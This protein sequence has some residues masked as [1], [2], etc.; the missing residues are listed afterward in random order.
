L[1]NGLTES[2]AKQKEIE[3]I[4]KYKSN[5]KEFGYNLTKGG[6]GVKG[7]VHTEETKKKIGDASK[8]MFKNPKLKEKISIRMKGANNP[9]YG[10]QF[11]EEHKEKLRLSHLGKKR[12]PC[13]EETKRKISIANTGVKKPHVGVPRSIE[14]REKMAKAHCKAVLQFTKTGEFVQ[15][16]FSVKEAALTTKTGQ[17]NI[18]SCCLGKQKTANGFIW[19][20]KNI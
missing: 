10:K 6:D 5:E 4:A 13:S 9:F 3:L 7:Y 20:F 12:G 2:E 11:T 14:C 17:Q 8:M 15:E 1:F 16:Y 18:S 19:K